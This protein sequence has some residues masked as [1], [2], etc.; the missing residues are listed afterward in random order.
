MCGTI[1]RARADFYKEE[2]KER[3]ARPLLKIP[4]PLQKRIVVGLA[5][6]ACHVSIRLLRVL[7]DKPL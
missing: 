3:K 6:L 4:L 7:S 5:H 2:R 1:P